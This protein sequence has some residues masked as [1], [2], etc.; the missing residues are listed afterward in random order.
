M[1]TILCMK[2]GTRYGPD[3]V[4]RLWGMI[5]R[6][7]TRPTRL[8]CYTDDATG[9][10]PDVEIEDLLPIELPE[11]IRWKPW[12]K[13]ALWRETLPGAS[14]DV[15][16][17]DLDVVVTG[18]LD[19]FF[20]HE[21]GRFCVIRNWTQGDGVG[22]TSCFRFHVGQAPHLVARAEADGAAIRKAY[23][24]EQIFVTREIGVEPVFWP[25]DWCVS[26]KHTL[27]PLWPL[28]FVRAARLPETARVV[29]FT[30]KPDP[31]EARDGIY[32][33]TAAWKRLYKHVRPTSWIA[34]HWRA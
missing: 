31:D 15:L 14:G 8:V 29:V 3:Y 4:N 10:H 5:T 33:T 1:Q 21:P 26:F 30:G 25:K 34:D 27:M 17:L 2:W 20:D 16:F 6:N 32:P 19:P 13:L 11:P 24:N 7:T 22:N 18:P 23:V 12:R 9:V 28:N